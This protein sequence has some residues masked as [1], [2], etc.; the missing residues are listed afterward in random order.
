METIRLD[1][2]GRTYPLSVP[3]QEVEGL[4]Q[5]A[6]AV[7]DQVDRFR[8]QY[9]VQDRGDLLA[10]TA[11]QFAS[12]TAQHPAPAPLSAETDHRLHDLLA[13]MDAALT[14]S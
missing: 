5:A 2:A 12:R 9:H 8:E 7:C 10:M 4:K 13:R 3:E 1:I 11:L 6:E 14:G